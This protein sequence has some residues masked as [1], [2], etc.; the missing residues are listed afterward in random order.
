MADLVTSLERVRTLAGEI[1]ERE[2]LLGEAIREAAGLGAS[3]RQLGAWSGLSAATISRR[4][5]PTLSPEEAEVRVAVRAEVAAHRLELAR[6][7]LARSRLE[8]LDASEV[9]ALIREGLEI[10]AADGI[11]CV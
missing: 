7:S 3:T 1:R 11:D 10:A 2:R 6:V 5:R 8:E 9:D 4:L